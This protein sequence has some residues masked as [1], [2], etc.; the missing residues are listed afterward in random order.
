MSNH[1]KKLK[2]F[3]KK[4]EEI[5]ESLSLKWVKMVTIEEPKL[6]QAALLILDMM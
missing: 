1:S 5:Q 4:K 3:Q 6:L 2:S